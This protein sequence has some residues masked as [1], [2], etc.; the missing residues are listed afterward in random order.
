MRPKL[1]E[2]AVEVDSALVVL[3]RLHVERFLEPMAA[4][5][6]VVTFTSCGQCMAD[7]V[8]HVLELAGVLL[9]RRLYAGFGKQHGVKDLSTLSHLVAL[10]SMIG[11]KEPSPPEPSLSTPSALSVPEPSP[12]SER[13]SHQLSPRPNLL[14]HPIP[15]ALAPSAAPLHH[16][17]LLRQPPVPSSP[18]APAPS[19]VP[20]S[21][22]C[23][24]N[25]LH[26]QLWQRQSSAPLDHRLLLRQPPAPTS[27]S[28]NLR[29]RRP[30]RC[31][32][33]DPVLW[34][35]LIS[36]EEIVLM[37]EDFEI[38]RQHYY[39]SILLMAIYETSYFQ[40]LVGYYHITCNRSTGRI[41]V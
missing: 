34:R 6:E 31:C 10:L 35:G 37:L 3:K 5:F 40:G 28:V 36:A 20:T 9:S 23:C 18:S 7:K 1:V 4:L 29:Q 21:S 24:I 2:Y 16:R 17:L 8:F 32:S 38:L 33:T 27:C 11:S 19:A 12:P 30:S 14:R 15:S 39:P 25:L 13:E 26:H 41:G 22:R